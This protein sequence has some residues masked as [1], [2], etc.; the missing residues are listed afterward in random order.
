MELLTN[1]LLSRDYKEMKKKTS[2]PLFIIALGFHHTHPNYGASS[3]IEKI[4]ITSCDIPKLPLTRGLSFL[5]CE[6]SR[7]DHIHGTSLCFGD[8]PLLCRSECSS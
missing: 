3:F 8:V 4:R 5:Y 1:P 6:A 2:Q 7:L